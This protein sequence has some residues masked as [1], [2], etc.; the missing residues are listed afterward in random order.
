M[1]RD[2]FALSRDLGREGRCQRCQ[3]QL[4][5]SNLESACGIR[6]VRPLDAPMG[7]ESFLAFLPT[8]MRAQLLSLGVPRRFVR[9]SQPIVEGSPQQ[10]VLLIEQG[11]VAVSQSGWALDVCGPGR[12][13]GFRTDCTMTCV[14]KVLAWVISSEV[15]ETFIRG[16]PDARSTLYRIIRP[17]GSLVEFR[18]R[19][20]DM[21]SR[22]RVARHLLT[23]PTVVD[24]SNEVPRCTVADIAGFVGRPRSVIRRILMDWSD[25]I[26]D[27]DSSIAQIRDRR[28]LLYIAGIWPGRYP[29]PRSSSRAGRIREEFSAWIRP[30]TA[31]VA[32]ALGLVFDI[33]AE[34]LS[35]AFYAILTLPVSTA[36]I[37]G[38]ARS[39]LGIEGA[40]RSAIII[41]IVTIPLCVYTLFISDFNRMLALPGIVV[42]Y[43]VILYTLLT[44]HHAI[45]APPHLPVLPRFLCFVQILGLVLVFGIDDDDTPN[46]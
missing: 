32:S 5:E 27:V 26:A 37:L 3:W 21:P 28:E 38:I 39:T 22:Q 34:P 14:S 46:P 9:G 40:W 4:D 13:A 23:V 42:L 24:G 20:R 7:H 10:E 16:E 31:T 1:T 41:G 35:Y 29:G 6:S 44:V 36:L 30:T 17:H 2:D 11:I 8:E 43:G 45:L 19:L 15:F 18:Q 33:L 25:R 12:I